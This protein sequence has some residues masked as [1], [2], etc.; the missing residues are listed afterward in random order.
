MSNI[1]LHYN[2][3]RYEDWVVVEK[4][5]SKDSLLPK[6]YMFRELVAFLEG[7]T[8]V[9]AQAKGSFIRFVRCG[10]H[11]EIYRATPV[12]PGSVVTQTDK[13]VTVY[14]A[15]IEILKFLGEL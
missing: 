10:T 2:R 14:A 11:S 3:G 4:Q 9:S 6:E 8:Y 7:N 1:I 15:A 12:S 5:P 13:V